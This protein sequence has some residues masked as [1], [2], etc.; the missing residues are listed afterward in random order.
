MEAKADA[1]EGREA[2]RGQG[3]L[4][5]AAFM[6][7]QAVAGKG[8]EFVTSAT[9]PMRSCSYL[10]HPGLGAVHHCTHSCQHQWLCRARLLCWVLLA[11]GHILPVPGTFGQQLLALPRVGPAT[12]F[13]V[14]IAARGLQQ[15]MPVREG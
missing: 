9:S 15:L 14:A 3:S 11:V 8:T 10:H 1:A 12:P 6:S 5:A 7:G 4:A 2:L 13:H